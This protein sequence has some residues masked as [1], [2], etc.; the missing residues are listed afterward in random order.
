MNSITKRKGVRS[1]FRFSVRTL[2]ITTTI[3]ALTVSWIVA[4]QR[5]KSRSMLFYSS[6]RDGDL[7]TVNKLLNVQPKLAHDFGPHFPPDI[8]PLHAALFDGAN[9]AVFDRL[10]QEKPNVSDLAFGGTVIGRAASQYQ[11]WAVK[12]L[13]EIG[14][15]PNTTNS[16]GATPLYYAVHKGPE[17]LQCL[18]Q[19][20]TLKIDQP[21]FEGKA[22]II[23][24]AEL[25]RP[26]SI[27]VLLSAGANIDWATSDGRTAL[28]FCA[29]A[30]LFSS[31]ESLIDHGA[32]LTIKDNRGLIPGQLPNED[33]DRAAKSMW[34]YAI[35][36]RFDADE[37]ETLDVLFERA[38]Q[39]LSNNGR[40][41]P[42]GII[43]VAIERRRLDIVEYLLSKTDDPSATLDNMPPGTI[44]ALQRLRREPIAP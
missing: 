2:L 4:K 37:E 29:K 5:Q 20:E 32:D 34:W 39:V 31:Y 18:V 28:H 24:A 26:D 14:V 41:D 23:H 40:A 42:M 17:G 43:A 30:S 22:A 15:D 35:K 9:P 44:E 36:K 16:L 3:A 38:P 27:P 7:V 25:N 1:L 33:F 6:I 11:F 21:A 13:I 19:C 8:K 10:L 12:R